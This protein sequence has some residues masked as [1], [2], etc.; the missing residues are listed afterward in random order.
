MKT[1]SFPPHCHLTDTR[2]ASQKAERGER[3]KGAES[4]REVP[5][6]SQRQSPVLCVQV[7]WAGVNILEPVQVFLVCV[8]ILMF[9]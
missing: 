6:E 5:G 9:V 1:L 8:S 7:S 2:K 4:T 3:Q